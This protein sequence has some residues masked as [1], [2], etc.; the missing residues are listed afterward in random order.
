MNTKETANEIKK[1]AIEDMS[2]CIAA[3]DYLLERGKSKEAIREIYGNKKMFGKY[4]EIE[5]EILGNT[6]ADW[7]RLNV[8]DVYLF[9]LEDGTEWYQLDPLSEYGAELIDV[10]TYDEFKKKLKEISDERL[11]ET[12]NS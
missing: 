3:R 12:Y 7:I 5:A 8:G 4:L 6:G 10:L 11:L 9:M 1:Q 2:I